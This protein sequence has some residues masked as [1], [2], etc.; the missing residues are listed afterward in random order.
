LRCCAVIGRL[1]LLAVGLEFD[2]PLAKKIVEFD[3]TL[4]DSAIEP[5]EAIFGVDDLGFQRSEA[6]INGSGTLLAPGC[7]RGA[8]RS[9][10]RA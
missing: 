6:A 9:D 5:L 8:V 3:D 2:N 10:A 4:L 1:S 7:N